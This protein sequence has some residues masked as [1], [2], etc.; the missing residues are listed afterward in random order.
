MY[1]TGRQRAAV[2]LLLA[3]V[4]AGTAGTV[5]RAAG[6]APPPARPMARAPAPGPASREV[7]AVAD[8]GAAG[9]DGGADRPAGEAA[10]GATAGRDGRRLVV[11]VVGSVARPGV[12][13]LPAGARVVDAVSAAGGAAGDAWPDLINLAAPLED[14]QR[15][16]VPSEKDAR[17]LAAGGAS[18]WEEVS[19]GGSGRGLRAATALGA[20]RAGR[21]NLN[22]AGVAELDALPGIGPGLA[23]RIVDYRRAHGPFRRVE[24]LLRVPGIGPAKLEQLKA[25]VTVG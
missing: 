9:E 6:P 22:R 14:G 21:V 25:H 15:V 19:A 5:W 20:G 12:Y 24:D 3:L 2:L 1:L 8:E 23:Q 16:Y 13:A 17:V 18:P 11:H 4:L 10:E 7:P